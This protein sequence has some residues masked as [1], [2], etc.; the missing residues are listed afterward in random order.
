MLRCNIRVS[1]SRGQGRGGIA[2]GARDRG[3]NLPALVALWAA[4]LGRFSLLAVASAVTLA[5]AAAEPPSLGLPVDCTPGEDCWIVAYVDHD[6]SE[7]VRD[8]ACGVATYNAPPDNAHKGTDFAIAD[9]AAMR[10]GVRVV[11]PAAG[12]VVGTR[13]G[14]P[15]VSVREAG[16]GALGGRDC[17]NGVGIDHGDGW[18]SQVCHLRR[19]SIAVRRGE[20]VTAGQALGLVGLSGATEYPHVHLQV[21]KDKAI[22]D[23]FVGSPGQKTCG[24]GARPLWTAEALSALPYMPTALYLAGFSAGRPDPARM[25]DAGGRLDALPAD[26]GALVFWVDIFNVR[27]GDTLALAI[28]G[29]GGR[30]VF[31]NETAIERNQARRYAFGGLRRKAAA[32]PPGAYEGEAILTRIE[33]GKER[34]FTIRR[35]IEVR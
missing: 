32:W 12:V 29:P 18:F 27:A 30:V 6:P 9:L 28:R 17:G 2:A 14:M 19:G 26:A 5:S 10:A 13:D 1:R 20:R 11:A 35:A 33:D 21:A 15:D 16:R 31:E 24:L 4:M 23:P 7:G 3:F 8:Y 25:R 22:V 34:R